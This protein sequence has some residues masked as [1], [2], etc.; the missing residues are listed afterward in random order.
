MSIVIYLYT[1]VSR[2]LQNIISWFILRLRFLSLFF[3]HYA[4]RRGTQLH[5]LR[6]PKEEAC[7][8]RRNSIN[9]CVDSWLGWS[10][11][12]QLAS[13]LSIGRCMYGTLI[14]FVS[15][16]TSTM[17][18]FSAGRGKKRKRGCEEESIWRGWGRRG[19]RGE[20][21]RET[22]RGRLATVISENVS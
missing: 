14:P 21:S 18:Q 15:P 12:R 17:L 13:I 11:G 2:L 6:D 3:T 9:E 16:N 8:Y 10:E 20:H 22:M 7:F 1:S 4:E 19:S 5:E